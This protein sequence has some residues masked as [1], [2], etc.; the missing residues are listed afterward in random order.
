[1]LYIAIAVIVVVAAG[2]LAPAVRMHH[3]NAPLRRETKAQAVT[4]QTELR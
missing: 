4:F 1:M 3:R 2:Y